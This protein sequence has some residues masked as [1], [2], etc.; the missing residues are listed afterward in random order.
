MSQKTR[1]LLA[2]NDCPRPKPWEASPFGEGAKQAPSQAEVLDLFATGGDVGKRP[3]QRLDQGTQQELPVVQGVLCP[4]REEALPVVRG[5]L[6]QARDA[7]QPQQS[8]LNARHEG[9]HS[10]PRRQDTPMQGSR[11]LGQQAPH[12]RAS[13]SLDAFGT[14]GILQNH[15]AADL[16][17]T[18]HSAASS[19]DLRGFAENVTRRFVLGE[20]LG[21]GG[22]GEV[23]RAYDRKHRREVALKRL[24]PGLLQDPHSRKR[25][26]REGRLLQ[27]SST[28]VSSP[29]M[30]FTPRQAFW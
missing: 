26:V 15:D 12:P 30:S 22:M 11:H 4:T 2:H 20:R 3:W 23:W 10:A 27:G 17:A 21:Q 28:H 5:V 14:G 25:L 7:V 1:D 9:G 24:H 18:S 29:C 6:C 19:G 13:G 8:P 16:T